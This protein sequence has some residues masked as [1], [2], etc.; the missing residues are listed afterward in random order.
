MN[1]VPPVD[2]VLSRTMPQ[3]YQPKIG[4]LKLKIDCVLDVIA[5]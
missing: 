5:M 4:K 2:V 3:V 1:L